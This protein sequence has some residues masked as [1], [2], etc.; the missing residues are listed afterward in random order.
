MEYF[1]F[2]VLL[3]LFFAFATCYLLMQKII[4]TYT[5]IMQRACTLQLKT[6]WVKE[7]FFWKGI[8][9][10]IKQGCIKLIKSDSKEN[11]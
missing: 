9:N 11:V 8:N 7:E 6:L 5:W 10:C 2:E 1:E 3:K 4:L